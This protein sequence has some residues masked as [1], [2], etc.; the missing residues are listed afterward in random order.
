[1]EIILDELY[2]VEFFNHGG[3]VKLTITNDDLIK[4]YNLKKK[5]TFLDYKSYNRFFRNLYMLYQHNHTDMNSI[6]VHQYINGFVE[7]Y[8][9]I[10]NSVY[11]VDLNYD[12]QIS[13]ETAKFYYSGDKMYQ[14]ITPKDPYG[15]KNVN[16]SL[17]NETDDR[18]NEFEKQ[19]LSRGFDSSELWN[20]DATIAKFIYPR[21]KAFYENVCYADCSPISM[22][23]Q[24]WQ[25]I[26]KRMVDGFELLSL[27][28]KKSKE[29]E[30][31]EQD[32]LDLFAKYFFAL[33]N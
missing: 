6:S 26:L 10:G 33:W 17:I 32:A 30:T 21:L 11:V 23:S 5:Y 14:E 7:L 13:Y 22:D 20:L 28:R 4:D 1:M 24:E 18:W 3:V 25:S 8:S 19:R 31:K 2:P 16:F 15:I 12:H 27:D 29:E 9:C